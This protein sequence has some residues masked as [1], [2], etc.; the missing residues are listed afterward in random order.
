M[1]AAARGS[2]ADV[3][4]NV[5][6][7]LSLGVDFAYD[8]RAITQTEYKWF[9]ARSSHQ[10]VLEL[11]AAEYDTALQSAWEALPA[12]LLSKEA[13]AKQSEVKAQAEEKAK[14]ITLICKAMLIRKKMSKHT[15]EDGAAQSPIVEMDTNASRVAVAGARA[16]AAAGKRAGDK[17]TAGQAASKKPCN[18]GALLQSM[19]G[20]SAPCR[21]VHSVE[22]EGTG[23]AGACCAHRSSTSRQEVHRV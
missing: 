21:C 13:I 2:L 7:L 8:K 16:P 10:K 1:S 15:R 18:E 9:E 19:L 23:A 4:D 3:K 22:T 14:A 5:I 6:E 20:A 12:S 17:A 11:A